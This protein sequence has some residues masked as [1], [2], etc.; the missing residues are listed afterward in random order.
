MIPTMTSGIHLLAVPNLTAV[1]EVFANNIRY[2]QPEAGYPF[3]AFDQ[4][5]TYRIGRQLSF[6][7]NGYQF[8]NNTNMLVSK[9]GGGVF[10]LAAYDRVD[11]VSGNELHSKNIYDVGLSF[12]PWVSYQIGMFVPRLNMTF[13]SYGNKSETTMVATGIKMVDTETKR[14]L[15]SLK[16][17]LSIRVG[18]ASIDLSYALQMIND[19]V[20]DTKADIVFDN[21][22]TAMFT[23]IF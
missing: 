14:F 4:T 19:T 12:D 15:I 18:M 21:K 3:I 1:F 13:E 17:Q 22:L 5:L 10:G 2:E 9:G 7:L 16:P 11:M 20:N 23:V 6:G 8:I